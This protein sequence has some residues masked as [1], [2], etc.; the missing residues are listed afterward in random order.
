LQIEL[1]F[2]RM[3][4]IMGLGHLPKKDLAHSGLG[5]NGGAT[6]VKPS[7]CCARYRRRYCHATGSRRVRSGG[8]EAPRGV[9]PAL[10][11]LRAAG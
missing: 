1:A 3:K 2:K 9:C 7:T 6:G 8:A 4:S 5:G 11:L 10:R